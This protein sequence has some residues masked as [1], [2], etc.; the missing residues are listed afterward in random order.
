[1]GSIPLYSTLM[2]DVNTKFQYG[3]VEWY[4]ENFSDFLAD[5]DADHPEYSANMVE[6]FLR[7]VNSW[8]QYHAKQV[9][10]YD[11]VKQRIRQALTV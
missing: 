2:A 6:G 5:V 10:A 7:C 11:D 4:E 9:V 3:S 1:M 8:S